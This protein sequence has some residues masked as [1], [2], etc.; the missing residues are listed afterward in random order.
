MK[1][2]VDQSGFVKYLIISSASAIAYSLINNLVLIKMPF[3][4][5]SSILDWTFGAT[6]FL[7]LSFLALL[8]VYA[9]LILAVIY[10]IF[11]IVKK[12]RKRK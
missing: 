9:N 4:R 10:G 8:I 11:R 12:V 1:K 5:D 3:V 2:F 7:L 6:F